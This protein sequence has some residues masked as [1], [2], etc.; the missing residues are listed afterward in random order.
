MVKK[1]G[2]LVLTAVLLTSCV[3]TK[4]IHYLQDFKSTDTTGVALKNFETRIKPDDALMIIV[5]AQDQVAADPFNL[6][7]ISTTTNIIG[8]MDIATPQ[9]RFQTYLVDRNGEINFPVLGTQKV[10]GLTKEEM[11]AKL[12]KQLSSYVENPVINVRIVNFRVRVI[13]EVYKPGEYTLVSERITIL[14]AL[15]M[16]GDLSIYG[17]R[18]DVLVI[19]DINGVKTHYVVDLTKSDLISSPCYYLEQNDV[20]YV[21]PGKVKVNSAGVGPNTTVIISAISLLLTTVA[22]LTR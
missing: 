12:K 20:V 16:A 18:K 19:R 5:T 17:N 9:S 14:D 4:R 6:P 1:L 13:G 10:G 3:S 22:L 8:S 7:M 2:L 21:K 15:S 11:I